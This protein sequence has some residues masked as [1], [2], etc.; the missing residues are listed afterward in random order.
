MI[1]IVSALLIITAGY[2]LTYLL[3]LTRGN[4]IVDMALG[5]LFGTAYFSFAYMILNLGF[6]L[7]TGAMVS[8]SI[9]L[10]P[11][12]IH[13]FTKNTIKGYFFQSLKS[14]RED[15]RSCI[16]GM[17]AFDYVFAG[18]SVI[19][20]FMIL[21]H[22]YSTPTN[23]DDALRIRAY[24]PMLTFQNNI[25]SFQLFYNG[26]WPNY[27]PLFSWHLEGTIEHFYINYI[28]LSTLISFLVLLFFLPANKG[29][30]KQGVYGVFLVLSIPLFVY[31][32]TTTYLDAA[33]SILFAAGFLFFTLYVREANDA[34]LKTSIILFTATMFIKGK[35]LL[36][37]ING[38]FFLFAFSVYRF[39]R[40]R[41][42]PKANTAYFLIPLFVYILVSEWYYPQLSAY[43]GM[44]VSAPAETVRFAADRAADGAIAT[45]FNWFLHSLFESGNFGI[46]FII[47]AGNFLVFFKRI[48]FS[49]LIWEA[50][51]VWVVFFEVFYLLVLKFPSLYFFQAYVHRVV[52]MLA[53]LCAVYLSSLWGSFMEDEEGLR[54]GS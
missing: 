48:L 12:I 39:W 41:A 38:L 2:I 23:A 25:S 15:L 17:G 3:G 24:Y 5:W 26:I 19:I 13:Y 22:G 33:L 18:L 28:L 50:L 47:L 43:F 40:F 16:K 45:K 52:M 4:L 31:H 37:G 20:L 7:E 44:G 49:K 53:V 14:T 29:N 51:F 32:A 9:A 34:D 46:L 35:G 42:L 8:V 10:A 36:L 54:K 21:V 6:G 27:V 30:I 1:F 11:I